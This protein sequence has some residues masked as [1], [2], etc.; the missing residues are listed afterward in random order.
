MAPFT[1]LCFI[2]GE[3]LCFVSGEG[4]APG[5]D[6][7]AVTS[8][9]SRESSS[10]YFA[11][12]CQCTGSPGSRVFCC[13]FIGP[14]SGFRELGRIQH[15]Q[16]GAKV[17]PNAGCWGSCKYDH[18]VIMHGVSSGMMYLSMVFKGRMASQAPLQY[19]VS[20]EYTQDL[21][22]KGARWWPHILR[23]VDQRTDLSL[24]ETVAGDEGGY[25]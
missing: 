2:T 25:D 7:A 23:G 14:R 17:S 5:P 1:R 8:S 13:F 20:P 19:S 15:K 10:Y 18:L 12:L 24:P 6:S 4:A 3:G 22:T 21:M 9:Q 11:K 16:G